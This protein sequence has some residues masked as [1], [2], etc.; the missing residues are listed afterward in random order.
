MATDL[1]WQG[2]NWGQSIVLC[3]FLPFAGHG[4]SVTVQAVFDRVTTGSRLEAFGRRPAKRQ[5]AGLDRA[6]R[7]PARMPV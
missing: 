5:Q 6:A 1:V 2:P 7:F 4:A 3:Y